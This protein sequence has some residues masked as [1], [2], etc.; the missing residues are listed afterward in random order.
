MQI[1][2]K[3][4][5][6][7]YYSMGKNKNTRNDDFKVPETTVSNGFGVTDQQILDCYYKICKSYPNV[8]FKMSDIEAGKNTNG[9]CIGYKGNS[10]QQGENFSFPDQCSIRIDV[11]VIKRMIGDQ[12]YSLD[13]YGK[14]QNIISDYKHSVEFGKGQGFEYCYAGLS[15]E[16]GRLTRF[17]GYSH[18]KVSTDEELMEMWGDGTL[19][20][21]DKL[22]VKMNYEKIINQTKNEMQEIFFSMIEQANHQNV[23]RKL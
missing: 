3:M 19:P 14:I 13:V 1:T 15:H 2:E 7:N 10:Y 8:T 20:E 9:P 18:S 5:N 16:D 11:D 12:E 17:T 21:D 6:I 22:S 23:F 4:P